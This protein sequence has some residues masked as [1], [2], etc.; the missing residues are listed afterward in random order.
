MEYIADILN[1]FGGLPGPVMMFL[2][3]TV[4]NLILGLGIGK[5]IKSS[6]MYA[7]GLFALSTFAYDIFLS[8]ISGVGNAMVEHIGL[9]KTIVDFGSGV[10]PIIM[11]HPIIIWAIPIGLGV[12]ILLIV[13]GLAKTLDV[14]LYNMMYFW[15]SVGVLT[16]VATDGNFLFAMLAIAICGIVTIKVADWSAPYIHE[17]LP[18]LKGLSF[19]YVYSCFYGPV[20]YLFNKIFDKIPFLR[21]SNLSADTIK[22][23]LG[24]FGEPGVAG[25]I[26]GI[27]MGLL[28]GYTFTNSLLV[29]IKIG[30]AL[31]FVPLSTNILIQG[32]NETTAAITKI[33]KKKFA[34]RDILIGLD[35]VVMSTAPED[36]ALGLL[37]IPVAILLSIILPWNHVLPIGMLS[38]GFIL[39]AGFMPFFK[40]NILKGFVFLF[41]VITCELAIGEAMA[42]LFTQ[43]AMEA[44]VDIPWGSVEI[45]NAA[46]FP[47]LLAWFFAWI[48]GIIA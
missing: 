14:D 2:L 45:T 26:L 37:L 8:T 18:Q 11:S 7:L 20:A 38:V 17:A 44:S 36:L 32:L 28:G 19:P 31:Y 29:G 1:W 12:N 10:T 42:P 30:A 22:Q 4:I 43:I 35:G 46:N 39:V 25:F 48:Q 9:T 23:K 24:V 13:T 5:S 21:D 3:F 16:Y 47:N 33:V 41:V 27:V 6:F 40:M 15:G 34:K